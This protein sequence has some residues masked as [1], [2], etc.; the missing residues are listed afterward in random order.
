M[1]NHT[2]VS[3]V[4]LDHLLQAPEGPVAPPY[5]AD[6]SPDKAELFVLD[7]SYSGNS[8][9]C[10]IVEDVHLVQ[11]HSQAKA[12]GKAQVV[13]SK[14]YARQLLEKAP[15]KGPGPSTDTSHLKG[16]NVAIPMD[17]MCQEPIPDI[18]NCPQG[19]VKLFTIMV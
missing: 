12:K 11:T 7:V 3:T 2:N 10:V 18:I 9:H 6:H 14:P 1:N 8:L 16:V 13:V 19:T 5:G 15:N 4:P 17:T